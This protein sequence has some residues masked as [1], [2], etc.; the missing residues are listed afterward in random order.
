MASSLSSL[1]V[2]YDSHLVVCLARFFLLAKVFEQWGQ[3]RWVKRCRSKT[4]SSGKTL[5]HSSHI[6]CPD[7]TMCS[8]WWFRNRL[9]GVEFTPLF[10]S[11]NSRLLHVQTYPPDVALRSL[12]CHLTCLGLYTFLRFDWSMMYGADV[13]WHTKGDQSVVLLIPWW[14]LRETTWVI[15]GESR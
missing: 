5:P 11:W 1:L 3:A 8:A 15:S 9:T 12:W 13:M 4:F 7:I 14:T 10:M 2:I 6:N